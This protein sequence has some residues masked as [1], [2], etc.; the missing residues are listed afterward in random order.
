MLPMP[1]MSFGPDDNRQTVMLMSTL[2]FSPAPG[3]FMRRFLIFITACAVVFVLA[4]LP[5]TIPLD[6][7]YTVTNSN[8][9][10]TWF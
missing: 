7:D 4:R 3:S 1:N 8:L 6:Y 10:L 9:V 2:R 5:G